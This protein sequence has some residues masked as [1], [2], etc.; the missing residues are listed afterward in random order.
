MEWNETKC[1]RYLLLVVDRCL[2]FGDWFTKINSLCPIILYCSMFHMLNFH[3]IKLFL[4]LTEIKLKWELNRT[5]KKTVN[6]HNCIHNSEYSTRSTKLL[7]I[8]FRSKHEERKKLNQCRNGSPRITDVID[9]VC[10]WSWSWSK[11]FY[12][13]FEWKW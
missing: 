12:H 6:C 11:P 9:I 2:L 10:E 13:L 4:F 1:N 7:F 3:Y 8:C 5:N